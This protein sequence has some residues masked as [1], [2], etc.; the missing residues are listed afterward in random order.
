MTSIRGVHLPVD[1]PADLDHVLHDAR[2]HQCQWPLLAMLRDSA[3]RPD[4]RITLE[5]HDGVAWDRDGTPT[6]LLQVKH[7]QQGARLG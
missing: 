3:D 4:C 6:E 5:L 1:P 7:R 2:Q